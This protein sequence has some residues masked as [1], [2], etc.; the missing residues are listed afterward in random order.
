[1]QTYRS[2]QQEG[3]A[4]A[5]LPAQ[6]ENEVT[7]DVLLFLQ[8][9][10]WI[11][12]RVQVGL[13][14][15]RDERPIPIGRPGQPDWRFKHPNLGYMEVEMKATG[16]RPSQKQAEYQATMFALGFRNITWTDNLEGFKRW[17]F[18]RWPV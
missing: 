8:E 2:N 3:G 4:S 13:F 17:Y 16:R 15:T 1:M 18:E 14:F 9:R 11:A 12:D 10:K 5:R 6:S 7:A